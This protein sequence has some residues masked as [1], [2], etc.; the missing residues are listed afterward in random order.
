MYLNCLNS[1]SI[2]G[3][4]KN[5]N[6]NETTKIKTI[7]TYDKLINSSYLA[8][9]IKWLHCVKIGELNISSKL[10]FSNTQS[11][12]SMISSAKTFKWDFALKRLSDLRNIVQFL[13]KNWEYSICEISLI[14][15]DTINKNS[16]ILSEKE[17][18]SYIA[19]L[20]RMKIRRISTSYFIDNKNL[21]FLS[22]ILDLRTIYENLFALDLK[23]KT[24]NTC[25]NI[26]EMCLNFKW[27]QSI[28][29]TYVEED[30][31][32]EEIHQKIKEFIIK[33]SIISEIIKDDG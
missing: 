18:D 13:P 29:L 33:S 3:F 15:K 19:V 1:I 8:I 28:K 25:I 32:N 2:K 20:S 16:N 24:S 4:K 26:L 27:I 10:K 14:P 22:A 23:V 5:L 30:C 9:P 12:I 7:F 21:K 31:L 17:I 6:E 11:I